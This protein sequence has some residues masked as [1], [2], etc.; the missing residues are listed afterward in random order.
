MARVNTYLNFRNQTEEAFKFYR[1][2]FGS[3]ENVL[4]RFGD[5]PPQE[6][7]PPL[8]DADK[9]LV[10]HTEMP[11]LGGHIL[12]GND[13]PES[14]GFKFI[15][16]NNFHISLEPDSRADTDK[17]FNALSAGGHV[18]MPLQDMFWG[19]YYGTL[20]DKFGIQW[21]VSHKPKR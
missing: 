18:T 9:N 20:T 3:G 15:P 5:G 17:L 16:G 1:T 21:M 10:M 14:L 13:C 19:D 12:M 7:M 4:N 11:I 2:V 6:G 8:S